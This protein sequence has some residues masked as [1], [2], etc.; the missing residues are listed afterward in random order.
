MVVQSLKNS[1]VIF[2]FAQVFLRQTKPTNQ[3]TNK[4]IFSGCISQKTYIL[5]PGDHSV[6]KTEYP[7]QSWGHI[8][9]SSHE[10]IC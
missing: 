6:F 3:K 10:H 8:R 9:L 2:C 5:V 1:V 4:T 7:K